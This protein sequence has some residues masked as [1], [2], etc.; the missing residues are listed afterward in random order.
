MVSMWFHGKIILPIFSGD[1]RFSIFPYAQFNQHRQNENGK[2]M[3]KKSHLYTFDF[4]L[5]KTFPN[6]SSAFLFGT[7][8]QFWHNFMSISSHLRVS[9]GLQAASEAISHLTNAALVNT[10]LSNLK[11]INGQKRSPGALIGS[12]SPN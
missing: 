12:N 1:I 2:K 5:A 3:M 4:S 7:A 6:S 10:D 11:T 8:L 9:F